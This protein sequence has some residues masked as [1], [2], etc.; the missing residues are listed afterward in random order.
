MISATKCK[1]AERLGDPNACREAKTRPRNLQRDHKFPS[2]AFEE[3][4]SMSSRGKRDQKQICRRI[5]VVT[6]RFSSFS[7][8]PDSM[9]RSS[10]L[11]DVSRDSSF[12]THQQTKNNAVHCFSDG[13]SHESHHTRRNFRLNAAAN[14]SSQSSSEL[15]R[16]R[17]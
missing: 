11:M 12:V 5:R 17:S 16:K 9:S 6:R 13:F 10:R 8:F 3:A 4:S 2:Q 14:F 7:T 15:E 1:L